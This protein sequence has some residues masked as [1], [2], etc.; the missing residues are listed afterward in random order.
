LLLAYDYLMRGPSTTIV[1]GDRHPR[2]AELTGLVPQAPIDVMLA[3]KPIGAGR[4]FYF[5]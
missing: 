3:G 4:Q 1:F 2:E 5:S